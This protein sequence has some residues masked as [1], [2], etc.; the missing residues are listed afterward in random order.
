VT[1]SARRRET[2]DHRRVGPKSPESRGNAGRRA[3]EPKERV[4]VREERRSGSS[5]DG[6][7]AGTIRSHAVAVKTGHS[8]EN[9][10]PSSRE[11]AKPPRWVSGRGGTVA[12]QPSVQIGSPLTICA[13]RAEAGPGQEQLAD[14]IGSIPEQACRLRA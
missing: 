4:R 5:H 14:K 1:R 10:R 6:G 13:E 7:T 3:T 9:P 11:T 8:S 2:A 12:T